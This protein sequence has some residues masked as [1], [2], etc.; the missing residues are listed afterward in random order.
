MY[1]N[2]VAAQE[3]LDDLEYFVT[4]I[5]FI[6]SLVSVLKNTSLEKVQWPNGYRDVIQSSRAIEFYVMQLEMIIYW[7]KVIVRECNKRICFLQ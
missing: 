4:D 3:N 6:G 1:Q 5:M 2:D 7:K